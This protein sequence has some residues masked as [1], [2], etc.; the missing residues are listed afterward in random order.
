MSCNSA[1][2]LFFPKMELRSVLSAT[3]MFTELVKKYEPSGCGRS[4]FAI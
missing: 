3:E 4:L 2:C 1:M